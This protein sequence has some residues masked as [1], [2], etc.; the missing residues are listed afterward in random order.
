MD[1][2]WPTPLNAPWPVIAEPLSAG[3][4]TTTPQFQAP[5]GKNHQCSPFLRSWQLCQHGRQHSQDCQF[6]QRTSQGDFLRLCKGLMK[7]HRLSSAAETR[8]ETIKDTTT[9]APFTSPTSM[10][11]HFWLSISPWMVHCR[12]MK[13]DFE[14]LIKLL[15]DLQDEYTS[16]IRHNS[17]WCTAKLPYMSQN[18]VSQVFGSHSICTWYEVSHLF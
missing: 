13:F 2:S 15:F 16:S 12:W 8:L 7:K 5:S 1:K 9:L 18:Q 6:H 11:V 3:T 4:P 17:L 10:P 14:V